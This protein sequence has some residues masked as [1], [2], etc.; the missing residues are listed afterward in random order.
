MLDE[1]IGPANAHNWGMN[2]LRIEMLHHRAAKTVMEN[3]IF[4]RGK[5]LHAPGK[6]LQRP[7]I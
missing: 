3:V 6:K 4:N 5:H 1:F 7:G 2:S